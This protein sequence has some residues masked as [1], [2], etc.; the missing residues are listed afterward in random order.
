MVI[1]KCET[2][3]NYKNSLLTGIPVQCQ[4]FSAECG[5]RKYNGKKGTA[6]MQTFGRFRKMRAEKNIARTKIRIFGEKRA[7]AAFKTDRKMEPF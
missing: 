2:T 5:S 3:E 4:E 6:V 1:K 7:A